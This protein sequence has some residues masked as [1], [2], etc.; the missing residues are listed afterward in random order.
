MDDQEFRDEFESRF[1]E[2]RKSEAEMV[3]AGYW[4]AEQRTPERE[5]IDFLEIAL[6]VAWRHEQELYEQDC[7][8][9]Y[10]AIV[11]RNAVR[12]LTHRLE[13]IARSIDALPRNARFTRRQIKA[14]VEQSINFFGESALRQ[15]VAE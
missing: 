15:A 5:R 4:E 2:F 7:R 8:Q 13:R 12:Y 6:C 3:I 14:L 9:R 11:A 10:R 1:A